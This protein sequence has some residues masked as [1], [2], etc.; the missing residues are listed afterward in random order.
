M[1]VLYVT[2]ELYPFAKTGGLGD[3]SA[4]LP[5]ALRAQGVDVRLFLPGLPAIRDGL[6][7]LEPVAS[8]GPAFG[9]GDVRVLRG[10]V[11]DTGVPA[12]V[13]DAPELYQRPGSPYGDP[14]GRDWEDNPRR[15]G[16]FGWAA[17]RFAEG[18]WR[19]DVL[20]AHDW[21][22]GLAPA[23]LEAN[24]GERPASIFTIHN[25]AYAGQVAAERYHE[26]GLPD[27]LFQMDG[28]EFH[29]SAS[30]LKAGLYYSDQLT[31]VS[32]TYAREIQ[33]PEY[34]CGL[35]GLL[36]ARRDRLH[37]ILNG[38]DYS[39]WSPERDPHLH[40]NY[41][42]GH[43]P[44]KRRNKVA[45]QEAL[46]LKSAPGRPLF[47]AVSRL[48][49]Q[50]GLDLALAALPDLIGA[51]AQFAVLGT[52]DAELES[53]FRALAADHPGAV[54]AHIGYDEA[55]SHRLIGAAD[56][57][58]VPSRSEPCGLTQLYGLRYGT[59]PLVRRTGGLADTVVDTSV[60]TL[61]QRLATGFVFGPATTEAFLD[62]ALHALQCYR[63]P[64]RWAAVRQNAMR[65]DFSWARSAEAYR[66]L[67][68]RTRLH[69]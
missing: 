7:G 37:G 31:T 40:F 22:A 30:F 28:L 36:Q 52:G 16:L 27:G 68:E 23:W 11:P 10:S 38:V 24:G 55:L 56:V 4:A 39:V 65:C 63:Q 33:Q 44:P 59:L 1:R 42:A 54:A 18:D 25:L 6:R 8:L 34:G 21:H 57:I 14:A 29:G 48:N 62:A 69:A 26:L 19:P 41:H 43:L 3:V 32:P 45:M 15:F 61:A 60:E 49:H 47:C 13:L 53:G 2:S 50:K 67:Y 17:A 66:D 20:H 12:Y 64:R 58:L 5:P 51:G 35:H 9:A 46:G